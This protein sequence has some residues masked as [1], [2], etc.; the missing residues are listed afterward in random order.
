MI[1]IIV[2]DLTKINNVNLS[3]YADKK[4]TLPFCFSGPSLRS[5]LG[6][7]HLNLSETIALSV[8]GWRWRLVPEAQPGQTVVVQ[9]AVVD[10]K[11]QN[12]SCVT[13]PRAALGSEEAV[14]PTTISTDHWTAAKAQKMSNGADSAAK[15]KL[16]PVS[17]STPHFEVMEC[18]LRALTT[19][20][21]QLC[22]RI[23]VT[24]VTKPDPFLCLTCSSIFF[25]VE[26]VAFLF[27]A[28]LNYD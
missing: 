4:A 22:H 3:F 8:V 20:D 12:W 2:L 25:I 13:S 27:Q 21:P 10:Y 15:H 16:P 14:H 7:I 23:S 5:R 9:T 28:Q 19:M 1:N 26:D 11:D 17:E 24:L 18:G 6:D